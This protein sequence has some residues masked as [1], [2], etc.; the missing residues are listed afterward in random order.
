MW[1]DVN[2]DVFKDRED[3]YIIRIQ[4]S[5]LDKTRNLVL[6][7]L[8]PSMY[9]RVGLKTDNENFDYKKILDRV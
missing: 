6:P 5:E 3:Q 2:N 8:H 4:S 1:I 7:Y 9:Y